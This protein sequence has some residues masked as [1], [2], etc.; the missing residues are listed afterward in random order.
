MQAGSTSNGCLLLG[1]RTIE[2]NKKAKQILVIE[3]IH[4]DIVNGCKKGNRKAQEQLYRNYYRAMA[5]LCMRYTRN[6]EDA[7]EVLNNGFL[8]V[9]RNIEKYDEKQ[10]V[11][12]T[13]MRTIIINSCLDFIKQKE[14]N[15]SHMELD[16][17]VE[18][19]IPAEAISRMKATELLYLVRQLPP[20][21]QA[22]FNLYV[23]DGYNHKEI[24]QMLNIK[25]GT[26]KWLLSE[27]RKS[28]QQ[29]IRLQEV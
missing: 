19:D 3:P 28:L 18:I 14:K 16:D 17:A 15:I 11:L 6:E 23:M 13:W 21:T 7:V 26:S 8:K 10:A 24:A 12:Y 25:E 22:V 27:A 2:R 9:F 1:K 20:A 5:T 4:T 29:K